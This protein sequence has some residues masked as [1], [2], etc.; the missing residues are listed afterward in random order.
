LI[1][2]GDDAKKALLEVINPKVLDDW[3]PDKS[4]PRNADGER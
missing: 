4:R 2:G 3:N 1:G